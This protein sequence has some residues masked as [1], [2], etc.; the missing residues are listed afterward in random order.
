MPRRPR[1]C[2]PPHEPENQMILRLPPK[3][4]VCGATKAQEPFLITV[5]PLGVNGSVSVQIPLSAH[6]GLMARPAY[7][8]KVGLYCRKSALLTDL[9]RVNA[10]RATTCLS[11]RDRMKTLPRGWHVAHGRKRRR[12]GAIAPARPC[13]E[14]QPVLSQGPGHPGRGLRR[15]ANN[16]DASP[17][18]PA[19]DAPARLGGD[20]QAF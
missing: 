9:P 5:K 2:R 13:E 10:S 17:P 14:D 7:T 11:S 1:L 19:R 3:L 18:R 20:R 12:L 15:R 6:C 8:V 16:L 4:A